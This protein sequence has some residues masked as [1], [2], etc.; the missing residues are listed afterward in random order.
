MTWVDEP[1]RSWRWTRRRAWYPRRM[2]DVGWIWLRRYWL[3]ECKWGWGFHD[4]YPYRF[5]SSYYATE[6]R[7]AI[8]AAL[9]GPEGQPGLDCSI[10]T[11][12]NMSKELLF[13]AANAHFPMGQVFS[14][15]RRGDKWSKQAKPGDVVDLM[16]T[17]SRKHL[18]KATVVGSRLTTFKDAV[19]NCAADKNCSLSPGMDDSEASAALKGEL[20]ASYKDL[21]P[22][23][24]F[25]VLSLIAHN[26]E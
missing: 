9:D 20:E 24:A 4:R 6:T 1:H 11:E 21:T 3:W 5:K 18:G 14:T 22:D 13:I 16:I 2:F 7:N 23:E 15:A 12:S 26:P 8:L 19:D 25:T 10:E 17:E